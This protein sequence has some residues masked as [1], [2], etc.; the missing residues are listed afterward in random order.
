MIQ[1]IA[2]RLRPLH[3]DR[4]SGFTVIEVMVAM[5][6]FAIMSTGIAYGI[7]NSL[8]LTQAT[9][10]RATAISLASQDIDQ[11]RQTAAGSTNGIF[12]VLSKTFPSD[13]IGGVAYTIKRTVSWIQSDGSVSTCGSSTGKLAYKSVVENVSWTNARGGTSSTSMTSSIAPA[14]AVTDPTNGTVIIAA[15]DAT[16]GPKVGASVSIVPTASG[17]GSTLAS[18]PSA[19]DSQG[20][21]YATNV[22]PGTYTVSVSTTG[23]VDTAQQAVSQQTITVLAGSSNPIPFSY[24]QASTLNLQYASAYSAVL[25]TNMMTTLSSNPGGL[26]PMPVPWDTT[27]GGST[28]STYSMSVFPF[29]SAYQ[30]IAGS[31]VTGTDTSCLSPNPAQW[32]TKN[33]SGQLATA[34]TSVVPVASGVASPNPTGVMM[35]VVQVNGISPGITGAYVVATSTTPATGSGDPGCAAGMTLRF[36]KTYSS[37]MTVALPYGTWKLSST[38]GLLGTVFSTL[39]GSSSTPKLQTPGTV[40]GSTATGW[41]VM[42]DPRGQTK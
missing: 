28:T 40:A 32:T 22:D 35:G 21:S 6:V 1:R 41:T 20:C 31:Y 24:D 39:T 33:S 29:Q 2:R 27:G 23:G 19:T 36:P 15:T 10:G 4:Q 9:R 3:E 8:Q 13:T 12:S 7:A 5:I 34:P 42:L 38:S 17:G 37:S 16:G 30:V 26:D 25:A 18:Q 11:L 14:N